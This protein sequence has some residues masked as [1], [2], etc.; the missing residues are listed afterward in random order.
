MLS[1]RDE[2]GLSVVQPSDPRLQAERITEEHLELVVP[3][4]A[5]VNSWSDLMTLSFID[6]PDGLAMASRLLP[7]MYLGCPSVQTLPVRG[8]INQV[9]LILEPV[10]RGFCFTVIPVTR[11]WHSNPKNRF[12]SLKA[13]LRCTTR[14][15]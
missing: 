3:A 9:S 10:A 14:F 5:T 1:S 6:H 11:A 13:V 4:A 12:A 15:G 8:F 2:L 7:R